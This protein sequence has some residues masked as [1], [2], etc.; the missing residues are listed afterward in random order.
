MKT[1]NTRSGESER[2]STR[3]LFVG[4]DPY[5]NQ[6]PIRFLTS[7]GF[8]VAAASS[9][10]EAWILLEAEK[11]GFDVVITDH[12]MPRM[13]GMDGIGLV[14]KLRSVCYPGI[15]IV[16]SANAGPAEFQSYEPL[17][18]DRILKKPVELWKLRQSLSRQ[19]SIR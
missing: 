5:L 1:A 14:A 12:D 9:E 2:L 8:K 17:G 11:G 7:C 19:T 4:G 6:V 16:L 15:I 13:G 10:Q 3:I 18:V